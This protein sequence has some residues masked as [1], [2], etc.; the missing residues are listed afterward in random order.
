VCP[1]QNELDSGSIEDAD[2]LFRFD[3]Q[4]I[5]FM[6]AAEPLGQHRADHEGPCRVPFCSLVG[7]RIGLPIQDSTTGAGYSKRIK[8]HFT[9]MLE[10]LQ[11]IWCVLDQAKQRAEALSASRPA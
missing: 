9:L 4:G 5:R 10:P 3:I 1:H 11:T 7:K 6:H 2:H 8:L